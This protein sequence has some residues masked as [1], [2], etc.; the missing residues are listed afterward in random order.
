VLA[1]A[2]AFALALASCGGAAG[3]GSGAG[4]G[5]AD[6]AEVEKHNAYI[7]L[8]NALISDIDKVALDYVECFGDGEDV[9]IEEGFSGYTMYSSVLADRLEAAMTYADAKPPAPDADAALREL[10]PVL[11]RY[12]AAMA[13]AKKYYEDKNYVDDGYE[14]AQGYHDVIIG[15][16]ELVWEK[17]A[18]FLAAVDGLLAGQDDEQLA[19]Y[20]EAGQMI[21][22]YALASVIAAQAVDSFLGERGIDAAGILEIDA[23]EFRPVYEA[24]VDAYNGYDALVKEDSGAGED[25]GIITLMMFNKE[26]YGLKSSV[27]ELMDRVQTGRE[28]GGTE[29]NIARLTDGTPENIG[30]ITGRLLGA[31]NSSIA[32]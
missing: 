8:Y 20:E 17:A 30:E 32:R 19:M 22:Y 16:Y 13:D 21:H 4:G 24:F 27:S 28:F 15:E 1:L 14:K 9:Y 3:G 25:E 23:D 11:A 6:V 2:L 29:I 26:L 31:Y 10:E 5:N 12:A 18:P 7:G